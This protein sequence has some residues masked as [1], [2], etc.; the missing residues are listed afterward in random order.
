MDPSKIVPKANSLAASN[1]AGSRILWKNSRVHIILFISYVLATAQFLRAYF[2]VNESYLNAAKYELG[3]ERMPF[4]G[5]VLMAVI[6]RYANSAHG[7]QTL[8]S[9]LRGPLHYPDVLA[10]AIVNLVALSLLA[11]TVSVFYRQLSPRGSLLWMP[12]FLVLW[13]AVI[14]Y[15]VRFQEA[16]YF[17]YDLLA[18]SLF[19]LGLYFCYRRSYLPLLVMFAVACFNRETVFLLIPLVVTNAFLRVRVGKSSITDWCYAMAMSVVWIAIHIYL[20][21]LYRNNVT[22]LGFRIHQNL[23]FLASPQIWPQ[24]ASACGFLLPVPFLFWN[25]LNDQ[26]LRIYTMIIP[27]WIV[28]MFFVGLLPES[29]IFGELIGFLSVLCTIIFER[30]YR[31]VISTDSLQTI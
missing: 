17:P 24:I 9:R 2:A 18:A 4:Q 30:A 14:T 25:L 15:V 31:T 8:A 13:M 12:Y 16:I 1:T 28:L 5:R 3:T 26:R 23:K 27:V 6:M 10:I 22:E 19:T 11:I 7:L 21:H 29:R 20:G